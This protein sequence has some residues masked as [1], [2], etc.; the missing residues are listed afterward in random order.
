MILSRRGLEP[1]REAF[2]PR[3]SALREHY[4]SIIIPR[5]RVDKTVNYEGIKHKR[6]D[7]H[8]DR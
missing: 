6:I 2:Y 5:H 4:N 3:T 7:L 8:P 1:F